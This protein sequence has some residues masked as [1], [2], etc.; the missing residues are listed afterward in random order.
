[1]PKGRSFTLVTCK[2]AVGES[3]VVAVLLLL[4]LFGSMVPNGKVRVAVFGIEPVAEPETVPLIVI[5]TELLAGSVGMLADTKAPVI[6]ML[7]GQTAPLSAFE[8][9]AVR[10]LMAAFTVSEKLVPPAALGPALLMTKV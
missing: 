9:V 3:I 4:L 7:P 1:M 6:P 2:S 8:Q 5:V 10:P